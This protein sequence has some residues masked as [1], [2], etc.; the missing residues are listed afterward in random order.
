MIIRGVCHQ[1]GLKGEYVVKLK[2]SDQMWQGSSLNEILGA[3][4]AFELDLQIPEPVIVNISQDFVT[5]MGDRHDNFTIASGSM[6][7]NFGTALQE[8]YQEMMPGQSITKELR[9]KL[10]DLFAFDV[11]IGNTDR[12]IDKPNFLTNGK[13]L[14]IYDHELAF[15]F[16][17]ILPF[18]RNPDPW[19]IL[20]ADMDWLTRNFCYQQLRGNNYNFSNFTGRLSVLG[21]GFWKK[22]KAVIPPEWK[23]ENFDIIKDYLTKVVEHRN[24]FATELNRVLL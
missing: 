23:N 21:D 22:A 19:L 16:I 17:Q 7:Y 14:L 11:L 1:S 5:N 18:A 6:G 15:S 8:G 24:Q 3:F 2:G 10:L 13:D 20:P 9:S 4:I 12:R